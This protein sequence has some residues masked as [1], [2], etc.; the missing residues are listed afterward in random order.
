MGPA[1]VSTSASP[2]DSDLLG[3]PDEEWK[4]LRDDWLPTDADRAYVDSLMQP[5]YEPGKIANWLAPPD[6]GINGNSF[7]FE[8]VRF[9]PR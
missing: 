9:A 7:D 3:G 1:A 6:R 5:V 8:Y 4:R 2:G